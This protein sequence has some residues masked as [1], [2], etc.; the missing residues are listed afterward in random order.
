[1][2]TDQVEF[3]YRLPDVGEGTATAVILEWAVAPGD[4]VSEDD[5]LCEVETE[6]AVVDITAPCPGEIVSL[7]ADPGEE[8]VVGDVF[9]VIRTA[10]PP[11]ADL[12]VIR[13]ESAAD[14]EGTQANV[15]PETSGSGGATEGGSAARETT[16]E[17]TGPPGDASD[18]SEQMAE[19]DT[20][21][22]DGTGA[23]EPRGDRVFAAPATRRYARQQGI[24]I[25]DVDGSGPGGRVLRSDIDRHRDAGAAT[26]GS[27]FGDRTG[28]ASSP[29][30]DRKTARRSLSPTRR[31]I[32]DN[33]VESTRFIPHATSVFEADAEALVAAKERLDREHDVHITYTPLFLK[34][35]VAGLEAY[36]VFNAELD[37]ATDELVEKHYY[38]V[39]VAVHTD[40]GLLVPVLEAVDEKSV[41]TLAAELEV[42]I[43]SAR[44][45]R[46]EPADFEGGT[47]TLTNTGSHGGRSLFGTPI[48]DPPQT[49]ILGV[50]GIRDEAVAV[51]ERTVGVRKRLYL[52][53]SYDHRVIDGVSAG[54]FMEVVI[55]HLE[56]PPAVL[57]E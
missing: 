1:M 34:A 10:D 42:V 47:F 19:S 2:R 21:T 41:P 14:E 54:S 31:A 13:G 43:D 55:D 4:A 40:A 27:A 26:V 18:R 46:L 51:D 45:R 22:P 44:E 24:D 11:A 38:H 8:V 36:P 35:V 17:G 3:A 25:A 12:G 33:M 9:V 57:D 50:S 52:S 20:G 48:I 30:D 7:E 16:A 39:G 32:A 37:D 28:D 6:K 15:A 53:L 29:A 56:D 49:G 5:R 23:V